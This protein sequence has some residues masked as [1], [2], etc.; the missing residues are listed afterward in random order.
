MSHEKLTAHYDEQIKASSDRAFGVV[1]TV[2]FALIGALPL[3]SGKAPH[4]WAFGVSGVFAALALL[5]PASLAP[6]NRLWTKFGLLLHRVLNPIILGIMFFATIVP[7]GL[8]MRLFRKDLLRLRFDDEAPSYWIE[9]RPI[10]P[11]PKSLDR[12]F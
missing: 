1:F 8:I 2:V 11:D 4:W 6:L 3:V 9:R 5:V 10:G 7:I 12:Q